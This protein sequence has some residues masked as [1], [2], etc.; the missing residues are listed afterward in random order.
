MGSRKVHFTIHVGILSTRR[1]PKGWHIREVHEF[2]S[3][4]VTGAAGQLGAEVCRLLPTEAVGIDVDSLDLTDCAAVL[5]TVR[6][7]APRAVI[8]C[9]AYTQVDQAETDADRC[10]AVNVTA[11]AS[12]AEACR[13]LDCPM[14]QISTDY[15]FAGSPGI[16]RPWREDDRPVPAGVY[17]TTKLEGEQAASAWPKHLI[18]R[19]CGLYAR[20]S[21]PTARNFVKTI[22]R[23]ART[24]PSLR[25]VDDQRCTPSY[26]PHVARAIVYLLGTD[27][28]GSAPWGIYNVTN[29]GETTW[30]GFAREIVRL[31]GLH[32]PV[33]PITTAE[34]AAPAPRPAY[35][36]LDTAAYHRLGGPAMPDWEEA[37]G[38]YFEELKTVDG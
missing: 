4:L 19:T 17:A 11:V 20:P 37:L 28:R 33:E 14:V 26:V 13:E 16:G 29:R 38:E 32:V 25:V 27:G 34:F 6:R 18:V 31:A 7:L 1:Q 23:L 36:V 22:L 24:K 10:R 8:H 35:S 15:L 30:C 9:A 21:N 3:I 12:L 2:M 5:E